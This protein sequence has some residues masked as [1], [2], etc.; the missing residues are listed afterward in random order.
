M[1]A[2]K[3]TVIHHSADFDGIF[4]REIA[5]KALPHAELI[6]WDFKDEP[7]K[8]PDGLIYVLDL[9][10]DAPFGYKF[11]VALDK[12]SKWLENVFWI[13]H[14]KSSI[15]THPTDIMG[16]RIDGVAA[17]RL[18]WQWFNGAHLT[19]PTKEQFINRELPE[20]YAVQMA[21]EY[22][23]WDKRNQYVDTFQF[24][25]R[26]VKELNWQL[27]LSETDKVVKGYCYELLELGRLL[28]NYQ[29]E[30]DK[31]IM[32]RSFLV[33]FEGLQFL[34][35]NTVLCITQSTEKI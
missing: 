8:V 12:A 33:D 32:N 29:Q 17:C 28:Q 27:L 19:I 7:I 20:P 11:G 21:G 30:S 15:E 31:S 3:T 5:K 24:G 18:A 10:V 22:D 16:Y 2:I 9:P 23:I 6:G 34:T 4:C 35:L 1:T 14:H 13:D 26:A 25:L